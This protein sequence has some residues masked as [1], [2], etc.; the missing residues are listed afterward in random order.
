MEKLETDLRTLITEE[1]LNAFSVI[2]FIGN[3]EGTFVAFAGKK[4]RQRFDIQEDLKG[5]KFTEIFEKDE[6]ILKNFERLR[7]ENQSFS[8]ETRFQKAH[9]EIHFQAIQYGSKTVYVSA[10]QDIT[11]PHE[12]LEGWRNL[13]EELEIKAKEK[14]DIIV[15]KDKIIQKLTENQEKDKRQKRNLLISLVVGIV[16]L[17]S[18][19]YGQYVR[20]EGWI[21]QKDAEYIHQLQDQINRQHLLYQGKL[22]K[23][24]AII[25]KL[26]E[27]NEETKHSK[28]RHTKGY[29]TK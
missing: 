5:K 8:I 28:S 4:M 1:V 27:Q 3:D 26:I 24:D 2:I 7:A 19:L 29:Q 15:E 13:I 11:E 25:R 16:T 9:V 17:L 23:K 10:F 6:I 21:Y 18:I 20:Y 12:Q 22:T 14:E